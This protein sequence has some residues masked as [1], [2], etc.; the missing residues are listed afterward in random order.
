MVG[1]ERKLPQFPLGAW[2][3]VIA[4]TSDWLLFAVNILSDLHAL[5]AVLVIGSV[6][7]GVFSAGAEL[8][9]E[10]VG[11]SKAMMRGLAVAVLVAAP[12][13]LLGTF[14]AV[15]AL[16]WNLTV[17]FLRTRNKEASMGR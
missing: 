13:P 14:L 8:F 11:K 17:S 2:S 12:L 9:H 16:S 7:A 1:S 3:V 15:F 10:N 4:F 6:A 5:P